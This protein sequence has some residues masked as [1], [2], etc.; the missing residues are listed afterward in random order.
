MDGLNNPVQ[1]DAIDDNDQ[2]MVTSEIRETLAK[3]NMLLTNGLRG[4]GREE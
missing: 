1:Y 2:E 3:K 4:A